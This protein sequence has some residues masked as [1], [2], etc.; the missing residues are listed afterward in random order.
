MPSF[1]AH[2][3]G[4]DIEDRI[5]LGLIP[6]KEIAKVKRE[7]EQTRKNLIAFLR[8][9]KLLKTTQPTMEEVLDA[10]LRF[11][12]KSPAETVLVTLE[13]LWQE[14]RAQNVPGTSTERPNWR[15]KARYTIERLRANA[16]LSARLRKIM[17][18]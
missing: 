7:R 17:Q 2:W 12:A 10:V 14:A 16:E 4:L 1:A 6:K 9:K 3:S 11:L 13:D 8:R 15:R 18:R 5:D